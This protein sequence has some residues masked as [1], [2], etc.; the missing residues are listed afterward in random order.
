MEEHCYIIIYDLCD[1]G[2]DYDPLISAIK[3]YHRWGKISESAWAVV[4]T[5]NSV[6]IRD[7]LR[8]YIDNNDKLMIIQSGKN[9]A[10]TLASASDQWLRENLVK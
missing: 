3:Q 10:W 7:N 9:A 1:P 2:R 5:N 6:Q 4:T 8:Q